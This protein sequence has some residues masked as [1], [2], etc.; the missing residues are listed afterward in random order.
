MYAKYLRILLFFN[1][2][3]YQYYSKIKETAN[4]PKKINKKK[5]VCGT[6][7]LH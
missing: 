5:R 7:S 6:F 4:I 2:H 3:F 1:M